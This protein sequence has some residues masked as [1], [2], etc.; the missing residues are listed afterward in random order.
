MA[1]SLADEGL[2]TR[3]HRVDCNADSSMAYIYWLG[4]PLSLLY[5]VDTL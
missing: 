5:F 1:L 4:R 2:L 3:R